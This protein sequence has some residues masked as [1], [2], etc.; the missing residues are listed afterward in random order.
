V[1]LFEVPTYNYRTV[2]FADDLAARIASYSDGLPNIF[3]PFHP[4]FVPGNLA[5]LA[6]VATP[7]GGVA[8]REG[9][10][11]YHRT[12]FMYRYY[13]RFDPLTF[14]GSLPEF[15]DVYS[16]EYSYKAD[17]I[18]Y[19]AYQS[20]KGYAVA[21][22]MVHPSEYH[23][24]TVLDMMIEVVDMDSG[25]ATTARFPGLPNTLY[26]SD[27]L[28]LGVTTVGPNLLITVLNFPAQ[29]M[30]SRYYYSAAEGSLI[31]DTVGA[32]Q[33]SDVYFTPAPQHPSNA[34]F[35]VDGAEVLVVNASAQNLTF[36]RSRS[37]GERREGSKRCRGPFFCHSSQLLNLRDRA[38]IFFFFY[39]HDSK[40]DNMPLYANYLTSMGN[41]GAFIEAYGANSAG[42]LTL[43][44]PFASSIDAPLAALDLA[45]PFH[46]HHARIL[47]G[48]NSLVRKG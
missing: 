13:A 41:L 20:V 45:T 44:H 5:H 3:S 42:R 2:P 4:H 38:Y 16:G 1:D 37:G 19:A 34:F 25:T 7:S 43:F 9:T 29:G 17:R 28:R 26:G 36:I 48:K 47:E 24:D 46:L 33:D 23:G 15:M 21:M 11:S 8:L 35:L 40:T 12:Y 27:N 6:L 30:L 31:A 39:F 10:I 14:N 18:I 32:P 22:Q